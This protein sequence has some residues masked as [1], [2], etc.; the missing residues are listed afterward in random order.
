MFVIFDVAS[1]FLQQKKNSFGEWFGNYTL[2]LYVYRSVKSVCT[3]Q[4]SKMTLILI[5]MF[6]VETKN[7]EIF[8]ENLRW[9]QLP[10]SL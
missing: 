3:I 4:M 5:F 1:P 6:F 9:S 7:G 8:G 10:C 2:I